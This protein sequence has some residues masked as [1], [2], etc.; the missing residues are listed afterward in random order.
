MKYSIPLMFLIFG[1][2]CIFIP[3]FMYNSFWATI[4]LGASSLCAAF[5][6]GLSVADRSR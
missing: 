6:T 5:I 1:L 2:F 3:W 4:G